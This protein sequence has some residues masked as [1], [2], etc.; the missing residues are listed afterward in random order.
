MEVVMEHGVGQAIDPE[1]TGEKLQSI[2]NPATSVLERLTGK[3]IFAA[4]KGPPYAP[5][6][7]MKNLDFA[8]IR[9]F[10]TRF[11]S[12]QSSSAQS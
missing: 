4:E 9:H 5:L 10:I 12:H 8:S 2:A 11:S 3:T 1:D 7:R 6:D